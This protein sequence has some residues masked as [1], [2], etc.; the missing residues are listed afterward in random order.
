M[1]S[2]HHSID[3]FNPD[4]NHNHEHDHDDGQHDHDDDDGDKDKAW[5]NIR[6]L[7]SGTDWPLQ[8]IPAVA[9]FGKYNI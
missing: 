2:G 1:T 6:L 8:Q 5:A 4:H 3:H 9:N 7:A